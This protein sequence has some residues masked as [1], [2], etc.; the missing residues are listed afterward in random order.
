ME[1]HFTRK[2]GDPQNVSSEGSKLFQPTSRYVMYDKTNKIWISQRKRTYLL[3]FKFLQH[4]ER[5][6]SRTVDWSKYEGWGGSNKVLGS[7]FDDWWKEHWLECFGIKNRTDTPKFSTGRISH[8][9]S[10]RCYLL[11]HEYGLKFPELSLFELGVKLD[12]DESKKRYPIESFFVPVHEDP[13]IWL[14][15]RMSVYRQKSKMI[16]DNV[17]QGKFP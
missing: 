17:C 10:L 15:K 5:D 6:E 8:F 3:W 13:T 4:C 11:V 2:K 14:Q 12:Q 1:Q 9:D 7:K 16:M